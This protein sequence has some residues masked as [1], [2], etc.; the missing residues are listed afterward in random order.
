MIAA[1][2]PGSDFKRYYR[3]T[4]PRLAFVVI[5]IMPLMYGALYL[6]AF[7]NPFGNVDK[8][9]VAIVNLDTGSDQGKERVH[10]GPDVV[11]GLIASKQLNLIEVSEDEAK[12]GLSHG[13]YDF[14]ITIPADFSESITSVAGNN[15]RPANLIFTY[16]ES[17][18]YLSTVIGQDAAQE[19]I[20]QVSAQ[21]GSQVFETALDGAKGAIPKLIEAAK[22]VDE[23]NAGMQQA[24]DG[25]QKLSTNLVTAK[26]G[27][28]KLAGAVD[29]IVGG[30][31]GII[32]K[33]EGL[34][35]GS[36][37]TGAE[38]RTVVQRIDTGVN[39]AAGLMNDAAA[40][41]QKAATDLD[42][43]IADLRA[44]GEGGLADQIQGV[45]NG[46]ANNAQISKVNTV[47]EDVRKDTNQ[48]ATQINN[49]GT[50]FNVVLQAIENDQV[51]A[52]LNKARSGAD[53]LR[54]GADQLRT[55][56]GELSAGAATLAEG[57]PK[58]AAGT[59]KLA[60]AAKTGLTLI[61]K[62]G[63]DQEHSVIQTLAQPVTL[64]EKTE[65]EA[66]TFAYGFAPFF[67]GLAL[68][69]GSIIAWMLF[70]PLQAR[71]LAQGLGSFRTVLASFMPTLAVGGIQGTIL[72]LVIYFGLGLT[73]Q[74]PVAT[75]AF[76]WL[77]SA[78]FLSMIQML[79][80]LFGAA[81]GRVATLALLMVMLTSAG[82][83]Y[84]VPTTSP[85]FQWIHPFDPMT[86]TVTGLRQLI[87]GGIDY[88]LG[89]ALAVIAGLT[90]VFL[91]ASTWAARRNRQYNMDRLYPPI[92]V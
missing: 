21:V 45:R 61:P 57:T 31:D 83:I 87:M 42:A 10:A 74:Y 66:K 67:L 52:D 70:T 46:I 62:W 64:V 84:P 28:D 5:L 36:G 35:S 27:S 14:T 82:G 59:E 43:V 71:P 76:M 41:Q 34:V 25:A 75:L 86:Y 7:W 89:I 17:N 30:L 73:P 9:P 15:P 80:A 68:F 58:L 19:V 37:L 56:L 32:G 51:I 88:R 22:S 6:W 90:I 55:G 48:L 3:G 16:D 40:A 23:L 11:K 38:I 60:D 91:A 29:E 33:A 18:N 92:E 24:N 81:V 44:K 8:V 49:P 12:T 50:Q 72:F 79:N 77:M 2:S 53:Q 47:I 63:K 69:V 26:D 4:M 1:F 54:S 85:L 65:N 39:T 20:N 13:K 78:M